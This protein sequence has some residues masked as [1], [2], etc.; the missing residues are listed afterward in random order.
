MKQTRPISIVVTYCLAGAL[1]LLS[2]Q[3]RISKFFPRIGPS[4]HLSAL[5][6]M[7]PVRPLQAGQVAHLTLEPSDLC[8]PSEWRISVL[9]PVIFL[10]AALPVLTLAQ[11]Q[12]NRLSSYLR[13][14]PMA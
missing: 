3:A 11:R 14:P 7:E 4:Q 6:K 8:L 1:I 12:P 9:L 5:V 2:V 13:P 10:L